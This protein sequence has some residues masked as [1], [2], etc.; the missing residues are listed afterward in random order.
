MNLSNKIRAIK[1]YPVDGVIFRDITTLLKDSEAFKSAIDQICKLRDEKI[2]IVVGVE[3][4][5]FIVGAPVAYK[6]GCGFVP[7]RKKNKLP[8]D[9][10][11]AN[12]ELEYGI[13]KVE[14]HSD[15]I[16]EGQRVL[17]IDDL[18]ATGGTSKAVIELVEKLGGKV[19]GLDFLVELED[20]QGRKF[21][22]GY[23]VRSI[24]KY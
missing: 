13:D 4:R 18:L 11:S 15:A 22:D 14:I 5:G 9:T 6:L 7:V 16:K 23:D 19:V 20:L 10:V 1:D 21:L 8:Y 12:Y 2:D 17:I 24:I 3:A